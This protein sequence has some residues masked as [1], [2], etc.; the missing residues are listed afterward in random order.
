M[1]SPSE[2]QTPFQDLDPALILEATET[3]GGRCSGAILALNSYENRV[4]RI[5]MED[6]PA[7]VAKF[8][9][10][11]RWT[12]AAIREEHDF[13]AELA[14]HEVPVVAPLAGPDGAT[15]HYH[16][17]HRFALFPC[18][19]GRA[20]ELASASARQVMGRF[21]GRIHAVGASR[22]FEHR[23]V[24]TIAEY[25]EQAAE[26]VVAEGFVPAE[27]RDAYQS[28]IADLLPLI[29]Q[30]FD[31][32]GSVHYLRTH[33]DCHLGN[34]LW[35]GTGPHFVDLDDCRMAPAIQDLWMLLSGDRE[36]MS[37]QLSELLEGYYTFREFDLRELW[38]IEALR[39]LRMIYY[40]AWIARRW[41][42]P[43]FPR[44]FPWFG[45]H[46][47]WEEQIL[48][49]REQFALMQESPLSTV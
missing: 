44:N 10:P 43:A 48:A 1:S 31:T 28:L 8:Y 18:Q 38:L 24:L 4:Y 35:T 3:L 11:G 14:A 33:G 15:L 25:G 19:G 42:D 7:V 41:N 20:P 34:V 2:K 12:D 6:A 36:Q 39:T 16:G 27:L 47:Y 9:R 32:A 26:F 40:C 37:I 49:L 21:I 22:R 23:P 17:G 13:A 45:S 46:R 29:Q 30:L 5:D